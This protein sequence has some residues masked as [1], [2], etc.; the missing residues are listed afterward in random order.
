MKWRATASFGT[1]FCRPTE[2][3]Y[4]ETNSSRVNSFISLSSKGVRLSFSSAR[5]SERIAFVAASSA[6]FVRR[7]GAAGD[8][9]WSEEG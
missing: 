7:D 5:T 8:I 9:L 6:G 1:S 2:R 4:K 3:R